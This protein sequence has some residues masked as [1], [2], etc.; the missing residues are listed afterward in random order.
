MAYLKYEKAVRLGLD[1]G[2]LQEAYQLLDQWTGGD[3]AP[4][5][6]GAIL[7]GRHGKIVEPHF[8]GRQGPEKGAEK[9]RRDGMFLLASI[10]KPVAY[11]G[12][13][14]LMERGELNLTDPVVHYIKEF[15]AHHKEAT[16]VQHLFTHT[17][18][19]P[20][21]LVNNA[22]LRRSHAPL[23]TF[24][25]GAIRDTVPLFEPGTDL[26]YQSMGTLVV[27]ELVQR[28]S[29]QTIADFLASEIFQPL[30][31]KSSSLGAGS[32]PRERLVRVQV[33]D[34][35]V[36]SDFGWNSPYWQDLGVPWGGMFCAPEDLAVIC[37]WMLNR[38]ELDGVR[39]LGPRT[40]EMATTNR[41]DDYPLLA[42]GTRR[43]QPWGL[44]WRMNHPGNTDSWGDS[45]GRHVFGHTGATGTTVWMDRERDGF[46]ILLTTAIR[47][48]AP[49]RLV[50]LSNI[51]ASAFH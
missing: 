17:S 51:V 44:G 42:E 19:M 28:L 29:G 6:G 13:L 20:D 41:L 50:K 39:L 18:G 49:W 15:A 1:E 37:Q 11:M 32:F 14:M 12:A 5:P 36:G 46:C 9:I 23:K 47:S 10:T 45:L 22:E 31:L 27:A 7:V 16:L 48:L 30:G 25:Q 2:R 35:Q 43:A 38:G 3:D 4:V 40:V 34:Y 33:P 8:S 26:S 24:I 21:M